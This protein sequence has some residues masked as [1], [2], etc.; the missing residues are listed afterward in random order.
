M[1]S[2]SFAVSRTVALKVTVQRSP[3]LRVARFNP[4]ALK[5]GDKPPTSTEE[6]P[7]VLVVVPGT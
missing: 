1:M 5:S 4:A 3:M 2:P 6:T 7:Q